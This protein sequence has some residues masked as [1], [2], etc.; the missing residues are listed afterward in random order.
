MIIRN[1][2]SIDLG[3]G[4]R[5]AVSLAEELAKNNYEPLI[6]SQSSSL[7]E[8]ARD[9]GVKTTRGKWWAGQ[10]SKMARFLPVYFIWQ[11]ILTIWYWGFFIKRRPDIIH[12]QSKDDFIAA[13]IAGKMLHKR[14]IWTDNHELKTVWKNV[15]IIFRN[16]IGKMVYSAAK[17]ADRITFFSESERMIVSENLSAGGE[18]WQKLQVVHKGAADEANQYTKLHDGKQFKF[19]VANRITT[20][21][22]IGEVIA[23]FGK[24]SGEHSNIKLVLIGNGPEATKFKKET[25]ENPDVIF[26]E[27]QK[28]QLIEMAATDVLVQPSYYEGLSISLIEAG[29]LSMPVI[30]TAVGGNTEIVA[31]NETG[32]L[33]P[34]HDALALYDAMKLIYEDKPL[35]QK[36][37]KNA[38]AQ[39]EK[40]FQLDKIITEQ[41]IPIYEKTKTKL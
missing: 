40:L 3:G 14:V 24:L 27:D 34:P 17:R 19:C 29:M 10:N 25:M 16:P 13:T 39:Y 12:I 18:V 21:K 31:N 36:L 1:S 8:F 11:V 5:F 15:E 6:V 28:N 32:I 35:R 7:L 9:H 38:R 4:E 30:A 37:A 2:K 22:G 20:Q 33:V 23:A 26:M 41:F